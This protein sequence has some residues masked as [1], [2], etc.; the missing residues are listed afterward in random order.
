MDER[1]KSLQLGYQETEKLT[2]QNCNLHIGLEENLIK[3]KIHKPA[4]KKKKENK[5]RNKT[6]NGDQSSKILEAGKEMSE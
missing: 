2:V 1:L 4:R 5:E 6:G 3:I